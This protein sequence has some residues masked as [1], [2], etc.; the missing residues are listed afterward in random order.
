MSG[1][2]LG[3]EGSNNPAHSAHRT[4]PEYVKFHPSDSGFGLAP[5]FWKREESLPPPP[6]DSTEMDQMRSDLRRCLTFPV[7]IH[8]TDNRSL[9]LLDALDPATFPKNADPK[10]R[11]DVW[12]LWPVEPHFPRSHSLIIH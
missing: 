12:G 10:G 4:P 9:C 2:P 1:N 5:V 11:I 7:Q 8:I 3:A 6:L